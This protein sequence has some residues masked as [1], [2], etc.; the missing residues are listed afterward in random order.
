MG[1]ITTATTRIKKARTIE[2][3]ELMNNTLHAAGEVINPPIETFEE[4]IPVLEVIGNLLLFF[5]VF[6]MSATVEVSNLKQQLRNWKG[7][8]TGII[9]QFIVLPFL[10]FLTVKALKLD[11]VMGI[12]LLVLTSSPGGSSSNWWCSMFNADLALSVTMTTIST[13]LSMFFLPANLL[14]YANRSYDASVVEALDWNAL[15]IALFVVMGAIAIGLLCSW[16]IS[17][18]RF[19]KGAN[20][21]RP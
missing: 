16:K 17:S 11:D 10:G 6:G 21:V 2:M 19:Q 1:T 14:L 20:V 18:P 4:E 9:L 3:A 7:I 5:L 13:V 12:T 15:F 8:L